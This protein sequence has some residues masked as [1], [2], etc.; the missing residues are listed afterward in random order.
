MISRV[1][2]V[3]V[4]GLRLHDRSRAEVRAAPRV[5]IVHTE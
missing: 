4:G 1:A 2:V 3:G 5:T